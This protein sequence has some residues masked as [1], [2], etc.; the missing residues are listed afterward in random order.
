MKMSLSTVKQELR[1]LQVVVFGSVIL[2]GLLAATAGAD[3]FD[4]NPPVWEPL[5]RGEKLTTTYEEYQGP[6]GSALRHILM[7]EPG[8]S[9]FVT[10]SLRTG[11]Q[12]GRTVP[13]SSTPKAP[14]SGDTATQPSP[15][16]T[17]REGEV[18]DERPAPDSTA[19]RSRVPYEPIRLSNIPPLYLNPR[20][21]GEGVW[22]PEGMP[23][24]PDGQQ[25]IFR[26]SY[27]PSTEYANATGHM[28]LFDMNLLSM[29]LYLGSTEPGGSAQTSTVP[30]EER[31]R[32]L[33]VTNALW[34]QKHSGDA[35]TIFRGQELKKL[36]PGMATLAVYKDGSV[37]ILEWNDG[38][39]ASIVQDAKQLRHLIVKDGKVVDSIV[40][41]GRKRTRRLA[42]DT[43]WWKE[44]LSVIRLGTDT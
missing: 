31:P 30:L 27:R 20:L 36:A 24:G 41:G 39:P 5:L 35:G 28:L 26:T 7:W 1:W 44:S 8:R 10:E 12:E 13:D 34:K 42:W 14:S 43:F 3:L 2:Q 38:I 9:T 18:T 11:E 16:S 21:P 32:L 6:P 4:D 29:N 25:A 40:K 23:V 22:Q 19:D 17:D 37:D 33:A 15:V